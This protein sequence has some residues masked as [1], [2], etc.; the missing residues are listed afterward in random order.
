MKPARQIPLNALR[1]FDAVMRNANFTKAGDELGITQT[2]VSHQIRSLEETVGTPLFL[3]RP[4]RIEPTEAGLRLGPKVAEAFALLDEAL[5]DLVA[6]PVET[7]AVTTTPTF[8]AHWL[9]GHIGEF[10]L[11]APHVAV[12]MMTGTDLVDFAHEPVDVAIRYGRGGAA[13]LVEHELMRV[14]YTPMLSPHLVARE[15]PIETPRDLLRLR[16]IDPTDPWWRTWFDAAGVADADLAGRPASR[17]GAQTY[18]A[19]AAIAG[20]GVAILTPAFHRAELAAGLL[21][22]PFPLVCGDG[23]NA[24]RLVYP[25]TRRHQPRIRAFRDWLLGEMAGAAMPAA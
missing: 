22:Q 13:G 21:V 5:A 7:L 20:H 14:D 24:Y 9:A 18:E 23:D 19:N 15:G 4:R 11:A 17:L 2:A 25:E 6:P 3:R 16:L 12:R 8:A 1:V 10:Q